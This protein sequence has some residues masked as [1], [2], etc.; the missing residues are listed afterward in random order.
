MHARAVG[1]VERAAQVEHAGKARAAA[2]ACG[3]AGVPGGAQFAL[4]IGIAKAGVADLHRDAFTLHLPAHLA[5]QVVQQHHRVLEHVRQHQRAVGDH[6]RGF[7]GGL[8]QVHVHRGAAQ[9]EWRRWRARDSGHQRI[10]QCQSGHPAAQLVALRRIPRSAPVGLDGFHQAPRGIALQVVVGGLRERQARGNAGQRRQV[11]AIGAEFAALASGLALALASDLQAQVAPGPAQT[12]IGLE[13]QSLREKFEPSQQPVT[14]Q[15]PLYRRQRQRLQVRAQ[16]GADIGQRDIGQAA[17]RL[18]ALHIDPGTQRAVAALERHAQIGIGAQARQVDAGEAAEQLAAPPLPMAAARAQQG[19]AELA[20]DGEAFAPLLRRRGIDAQAV[21]P[22][23]V[24]QQQVHL[25]QRQRRRAA[26]LVGP[27]QGAI[28]HH[29]LGLGEQP[30]G[31]A[32]IAGRG[33]RKRQPGDENAPVG[34]AADIEFGAL[35]VQLLEAQAPQRARRQGQ[36]HA[37]QAQRGAAL[38]I[39][40]GHVAE[41]DR[42][43][44]PLAARRDRADAHRYPQRAR[45]Q[46]FQRSAKLPDTRHNPAVKRAPAEGQHQCQRQQQTQR[47]PRQPRRRFE[48]ACGVDRG[49]VHGRLGV[50]GIITRSRCAGGSVPRFSYF[51]CRFTCGSVRRAGHAD[52]PS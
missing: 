47:P 45:G 51:P 6:H 19:L 33:R 37:R 32:G 30:V 46:G 42:R 9:T 1:A 20:A 12:V 41:L 36:D 2:R 44:Q 5:A 31:G 11:Q 35:D 28:A 49:F 52:S 7:A 3:V 29:H 34:G 48:Q 40:Q 23:A 10:G 4:R 14:A 18:P 26:Q 22:A 21:A 17:D 16:R 13:L 38:R 8:R 43:D 24:A 15:A 39:E 27:A 50:A 25:A